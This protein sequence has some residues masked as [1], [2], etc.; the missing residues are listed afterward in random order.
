MIRYIIEEGLFFKRNQEGKTAFDLAASIGNKEFLRGIIERIGEK[1]NEN[2]FD[3][4]TLLC[5][6]VSYNFM[7]TLINLNFLR[8][9]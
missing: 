2:E 3:I 8:I 4:R 1:L 7:V 9:I 5:P 6:E